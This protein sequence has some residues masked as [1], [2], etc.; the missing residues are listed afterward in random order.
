MKLK[1]ETASASSRELK[2]IAETMLAEVDSVSNHVAVD[3][4]DPLTSGLIRV[5]RN[6]DRL[7]IRAP[8]GVKVSVRMMVRKGQMLWR[9]NRDDL[10]AFLSGNPLLLSFLKSAFPAS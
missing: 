4:Y 3:R 9:E 5:F 7:H 8:R 1:E 2:G 10:A 6:G